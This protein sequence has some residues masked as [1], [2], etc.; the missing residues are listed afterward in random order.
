MHNRN[1]DAQDVAIANGIV[2][3]ALASESQDWSLIPLICRRVEEAHAVIRRVQQRKTRAYP[4]LISAEVRFV[5]NLH[6]FRTGTI[7]HGFFLQNYDSRAMTWSILRCT[8]LSDDKLRRLGRAALLQQIYNYGVNAMFKPDAS[9]HPTRAAITD[10]THLRRSGEQHEKVGTEA[11]LVV[12]LIKAVLPR[13]AIFSVDA[14]VFEAGIHPSGHLPPSGLVDRLCACVGAAP[15]GGGGGAP[16]IADASAVP[17]G[18]IVP[19]PSCDGM[20]SSVWAKVVNV[21]PELRH[22]QH[23]AGAEASSNYIVVN[24]LLDCV[25]MSDNRLAF[26]RID[27][28]PVYLKVD[29]A[30]AL[31][32]V[33][34]LESLTVW[35]VYV[36][37][38]FLS[39]V[40][41]LNDDFIP[42]I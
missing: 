32:T 4:H 16:A 40:H 22:L 36:D 41:S 35:E 23:V 13:D 5:E 29:A 19:V 21:H 8:G 37:N 24:K 26:C 14:K 30:F 25:L 12:D 28:T 10:W 7:A 15:D 31:H 38:G 6:T 2:S 9:H 42:P 27:A 33:D 18:A 1:S 17:D 11:K 39:K 3:P 20:R 34:A